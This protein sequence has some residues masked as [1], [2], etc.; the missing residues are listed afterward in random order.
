MTAGRTVM[1][2]LWMAALALAVP[3]W[4]AAQQ[5][6]SAATARATFAGGCFW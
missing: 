1:K 3:G 2:M 4:C 6:A 5:P